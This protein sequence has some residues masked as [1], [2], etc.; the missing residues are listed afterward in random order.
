MNSQSNK[1]NIEF[2]SAEGCK[3]CEK[4]AEQLKNIINNRLP[5]VNLEH[6]NMTTEKG[7]KLVREYEIMSS[8]GIIINGRLFSSGNIKKSALER[9]INNL[10]ENE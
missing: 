8:P 5:S 4:V 3:N 2:V 7:Q 1:V 10:V 9:K 6:I